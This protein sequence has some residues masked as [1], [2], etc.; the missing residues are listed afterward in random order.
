[1]RDER[2]PV[3]LHCCWSESTRRSC[4]PCS[5]L[6]AAALHRQDASD[7]NHQ[8]VH[9]R[10][11]RLC[12]PLKT[13]THTP[14]W[15]VTVTCLLPLPPPALWWLWRPKGRRRRNTLCSRKWK[16]SEPVTPCWACWCGESIIRWVCALLNVSN[17]CLHRFECK[18][19]CWS[20]VCE[21]IMRR[22]M[23]WAKCLYLSCCSQTTLKPA[24]RSKSTTTSST[25]TVLYSTLPDCN[26]H[27]T[28]SCD[29]HRFVLL[30]WFICQPMLIR[31]CRRPSW[32]QQC[33]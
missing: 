7:D 6:P 11:L 27:P 32:E 31:N 3:W 22:L 20:A 5:S 30:W 2:T 24:P 18:Y 28:A 21:W 26:L 4:F 9:S 33:H 19:V 23:T 15:S 25:S 1:M 12:S 29:L 16:F 14:V 10:T 17:L 8:P 13:K